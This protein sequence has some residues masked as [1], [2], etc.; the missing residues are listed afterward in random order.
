MNW[1]AHER[2]GRDGG[3]RL[4]ARFENDYLFEIE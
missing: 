4:L 3:F 2:N 1:K